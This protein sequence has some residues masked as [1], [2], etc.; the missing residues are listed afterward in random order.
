MVQD[1]SV[2]FINIGLKVVRVV[3]TRFLRISVPRNF[4]NFRESQFLK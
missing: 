3:I 1:F 4:K 2:Q